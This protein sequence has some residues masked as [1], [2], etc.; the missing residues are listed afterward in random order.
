[1]ENEPK[2][3]KRSR[4]NRILFGVCGGLGEYFDV[5]PVWFRLLFVLFGLPGGV[6]GILLYIIC[7]IVIPE[8]AE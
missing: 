1:M 5:D 2:T 4:S 7:M 8:E 3:L 6:P